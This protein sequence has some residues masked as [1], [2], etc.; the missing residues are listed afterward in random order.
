MRIKFLPACLMIL[1]VLICTFSCGRRV[2]RGYS[3]EMPAVPAPAAQPTREDLIERRGQN[4]LMISTI[5]DKANQDAAIFR[6]NLVEIEAEL[7]KLKAKEAAPT[8]GQ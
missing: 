3:A 5:M 2:R 4:K 6:K 8:K 7:E 1:I